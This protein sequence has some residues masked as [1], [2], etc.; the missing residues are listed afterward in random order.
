MKLKFDDIFFLYSFR[1]VRGSAGSRKSGKLTDISETT[2]VNEFSDAKNKA[3]I[4][5][6]SRPSKVTNEKNHSSMMTLKKEG[7]VNF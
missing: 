3:E 6:Q 1:A 7:K 5:E 4:L 2:I